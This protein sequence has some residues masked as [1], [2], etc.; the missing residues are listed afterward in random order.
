MSHEMVNISLFSKGS[1]IVHTFP[2]T[3]LKDGR[4]YNRFVDVVIL[5]GGVIC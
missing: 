3:E 5:V 1:E 2:A 4:E